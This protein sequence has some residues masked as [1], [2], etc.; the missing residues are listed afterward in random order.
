MEVNDTNEGRNDEQAES[1]TSALPNDAVSLLRFHHPGLKLTFSVRER[2]PLLVSD[3]E[4]WEEA[5]IAAQSWK[6]PTPDKIL[7]RYRN[8]AAQKKAIL[9]AG[10]HPGETRA[11]REER[12]TR[13]AQRRVM[14][15]I[16]DNPRPYW[17]T[18][19]G[20]KA[21]RA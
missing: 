18:M 11:E 19:Y 16:E 7:S 6:H 10:G 2:L 14:A 4:V 12:E 1:Q 21:A 20:D 5:L 3:L 9:A 8:E 17:E 15:S 13:E